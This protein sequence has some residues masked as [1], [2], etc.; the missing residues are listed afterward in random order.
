MPDFV[1][2][3]GLSGIP[4]SN[5]WSNDVLH[6][7]RNNLDANLPNTKRS[8]SELTD[9]GRENA[10]W[11]NGVLGRAGILDGKT[12]IICASGPSLAG[13]AEEIEGYRQLGDVVVMSLNRAM[14]YIR[15]DYCVFVERWAPD[16][17]RDETVFSLQADGALITC[18][19]AHP[20]MA[21]GWRNK[22]HIYWG[23]VGL[24][25]DPAEPRLTQ[26]PWIDAMA[27]TS[28][29]VAVRCAYEM[30][31][32]KIV[33][34]G[35][36]YSSA[37]HLGVHELD[38]ARPVERALFDKYRSASEAV[39][40]GEGPKAANL[41]EEAMDEEKA[42]REKAFSFKWIVDTF[43]F[44]QPFE[45]TEYTKDSRFARW[46]P[47]QAQDGHM[48]GTTT[49]LMTYCE[50]IKAVFG[51]IESGSDAKVISATPGGI[52]NWSGIDG[53]HPPMS[54]SKAL[55]WK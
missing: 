7:V 25:D 21:E 41:A 6:M 18:P 13:M 5:R 46:T 45:K 31:A 9:T 29:A 3:D 44:D 24:G 8:F 38:L 47:I 1:K 32:A 33:L 36:D 2:H 26:L 22:D 17:W 55:E 35:F 34:V 4:T 54:L 43:Y 12:V 48:V 52:L 11:R 40:A 50:Q 20:K 30:G 39:V 28:A 49:E 14:R 27:S 19:Q 15:S 23:R 37:M 51:C 53:S 10:R 16:D 42:L